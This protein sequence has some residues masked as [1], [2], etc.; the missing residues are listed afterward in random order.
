M[1]LSKKEQTRATRSPFHFCGHSQP[2]LYRIFIGIAGVQLFFMSKTLEFGIQQ[3]AEPH[4]YNNPLHGYREKTDFELSPVTH[5]TTSRNFTRAVVHMGIHKTG[6]TTL[7]AHT[8]THRQRL[9]EDGYEMPWGWGYDRHNGKGVKQPGLNPQFQGDFARCFLAENLDSMFGNCHP[10]LLDYGSEI[11]REGKHLFISAENFVALQEGEGLRTLQE[12]VSQWD[13][14]RIIIFH[15]RFYDWVSSMHNEQMKIKIP[16]RRENI[17]KFLQR[18]YNQEYPHFGMWYDVTAAPLAVRL[19]NYFSKEYIKIR[20]YH[21]DSRDGKLSTLF[22]CETLPEAPSTC[23]AIRREETSGKRN[24]RQTMD[25]RYLAEAAR[26]AKLLNYQPSRQ[27][28]GYMAK[29]LSNYWEST[30]NL[31]TDDFPMVCP[32]Q[33]ILDAIWNVTLHSE[34]MLVELGELEH[35]EGFESEMRLEFEDA[36]R[37]SLCALDVKTML[38]DERWQSFFKSLQ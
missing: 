27:N 7:Q 17:V 33:H 24:A 10:D 32:P 30:L 6:T 29:K 13:E 37:M 9:Q 18:N 22:F 15:R 11:A 34:K 26:R 4:K 19:R 31:P 2:S 36:S 14:V 38:E 16:V 21:E 23:A 1:R 35:R 3:T 20:N 12:Y 25:Y 28:E 5:A 8:R